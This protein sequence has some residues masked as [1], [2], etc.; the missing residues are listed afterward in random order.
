MAPG[1]PLPQVLVATSPFKT[2]EDVFG[3]NHAANTADVEL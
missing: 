2:S 1:P 3:F